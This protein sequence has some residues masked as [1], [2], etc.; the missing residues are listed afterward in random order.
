MSTYQA[1]RFKMDHIAILPTVRYG[2]SNKYAL[3]LWQP[4]SKT[5]VSSSRPLAS[6]GPV[7]IQY[8][9][10]FSYVML[11]LAHYQCYMGKGYDFHHR[12]TVHTTS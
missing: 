12:F 3:G 10:R 5:D 1:Y 9:E 4:L 8:W 7:A 2:Y 11:L 6:P